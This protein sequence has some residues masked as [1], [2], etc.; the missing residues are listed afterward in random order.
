MPPSESA[1]SEPAATAD[2][3]AP[4]N[5]T[6]SAPE[7]AET[8]PV[9]ASDVPCDALSQLTMYV[10]PRQGAVLWRAPGYGDAEKVAT[11]P[12]NEALT[13]DCTTVAYVETV[14]EV[15]ARAPWHRV[16]WGDRIGWMR[17]LHLSPDKH[18]FSRS[19]AEFADLFIAHTSVRRPLAPQ[20]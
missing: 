1:P 11:V 13:A 12:F 6:E 19:F 15:R 17:M 3:D 20:V 7:A 2:T 8:D 4:P 9:A 14:G 10:S 5:D 18:V 16:R